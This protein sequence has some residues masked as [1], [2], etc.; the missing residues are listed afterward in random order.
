M[1]DNAGVDA[2]IRLTCALGSIMTKPSV[3]V[4]SSTEGL[5]FARAVRANLMKDA[6]FTLGAESLASPHGASVEPLLHSLA[7]FDFAVVVLAPEDLAAGKD[8]EAET[9]SPHGA[10]LLQLGLLIG[11]LGRSR[12]LIVV[13][14]GPKVKVPAEL[15]ALATATYEWPRKDKKHKMALTAACDRI[16]EIIR[17][18]GISEAKAGKQMGELKAQQ[19]STAVRLHAVERQIDRLFAFSMSDSMFHNLRKI[20][21]GQ[22]GHF[23]NSEGLRRELRH[24]RDLGYVA[25]HAPV[26]VLPEEGYEL[27]EH[28]AITTD[29]QRFVKLREDLEQEELETLNANMSEVG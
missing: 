16:R 23:F 11:A 29:G 3:L 4:G 25:L 17:D 20:A 24:L 26:N 7:R 12:A 13:P 19:E 18:L 22:F 14:S 28:V 15:A 10:L 21:G 5:E 2:S 1:R 27:S 6:D 9:L 8:A